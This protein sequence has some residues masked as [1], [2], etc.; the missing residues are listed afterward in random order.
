MTDRLRELMDRWIHA[1]RDGVPLSPADL[2]ADA[3]EC[4]PELER[5]VEEFRA[6]TV[7]RPVPE[8]PAVGDETQSEVLGYPP[9]R[10]PDTLAHPSDANAAGEYPSELGGFRLTKILGEGGMGRV[11]EGLDARLKRKIAVK[12]MRPDENFFH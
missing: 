1:H 8:T 6:G 4:L 7:T 9:T 3:P 10:F 11:Y 12:V 5:W 2:C